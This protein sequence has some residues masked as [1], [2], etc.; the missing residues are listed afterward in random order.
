MFIVWTFQIK[1]Q[2]LVK[3]KRE[4]NR[5]LCYQIGT[6]NDTIIKNKTDLFYIKIPDSLKMQHQIMIENGKINKT[7]LSHTYLLVPIIGMKYSQH[8]R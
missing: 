6:K 2:H 5:F 4:D 3:L 1:S 7:N 8:L